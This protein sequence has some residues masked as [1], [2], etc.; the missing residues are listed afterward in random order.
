M[1]PKAESFQ[2]REVTKDVYGKITA[3][4]DTTYYGVIDR[5]TQFRSV[6][7]SASMVGEGMVFTDEFRANTKLGA[8]IIIDSLVFTIT[9]VFDA[10]A[11]G[12]YHH[13][14]IMYG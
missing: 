13:T 9:Q 5:Q 10:V 2:L 8:E 12:K 1:I 7:G 11:L 3:T 14:E 4:T 6:G